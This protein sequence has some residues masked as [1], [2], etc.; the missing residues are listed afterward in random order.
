MKSYVELMQQLEQEI[1][2][3][4]TA[5][6]FNNVLYYDKYNQYKKLQEY[7]KALDPLYCHNRLIVS[8]RLNKI[9]DNLI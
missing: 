3:I 7:E 2:A 1:N 8:D 9:I 6:I 5:E 4:C